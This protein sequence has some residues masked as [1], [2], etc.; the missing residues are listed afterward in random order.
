MEFYNCINCGEITTVPIDKIDVGV[1]SGIKMPPNNSCFCSEKCY[2][3][4]LNK[5]IE[6]KPLFNL[7]IKK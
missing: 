5:P 4:D 1:G 2:S 7:N 3:E 6:T